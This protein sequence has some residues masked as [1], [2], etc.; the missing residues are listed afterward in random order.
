MTV[1]NCEITIRPN[2]A[3]QILSKQEANQLCDHSDK[4]LNDLLRR[5]ALAVLNTG[6]NLDSGEKLLEMHPE[7]DIKVQSR[8]R[9][10]E[11]ILCNPPETAFIDGEMIEGLREHLFAVVRDLIYVRNSII[12]SGLFDL[13]TSK[14]I[15]NAVFHILRNAEVLRTNEEPNLVACW[16]GHAVSRREYEYSRHVGISLGERRLNIC[17]GCG[18]GVMKGPMRGAEAGHH[19]QRFNNRRYIGLSEPGIIA[20]E[21]PNTVVNELV[22]LPDIEKRLEAFVRLAHGIVIFPGGPGTLEELLYI[23]SIML[24]PKNANL[25]YPLVLT[26]D[27]G[28]H[29]YFDE[30]KH[31]I[32]ATLGEI[33]AERLNIILGDATSVA[34]YMRQSM[35][36]VKEDRK[37]TSDAYYF[38]WQ[39]HIEPELQMP[40]EPTHASMRALNLT[41]NQPAHQLAAQLRCAFSGIVAGNVKAEGLRA[42]A[43][44]GPFELKGDPQ[45]MQALGRLLD[46]M[47]QQKRMKIDADNYIPSYRII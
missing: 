27:H 37:Q 35:Q 1:K 47:I 44:H 17:T 28:S 42:I 5:C 31:F 14:G 20:A 23:L 41:K 22:I 30:V 15:T 16:G 11:L 25:P 39:L 34:S 4:G 2:G 26:G 33:A 19:N 6:N 13:T 7:F 46:F 38:N 8:G 12:D 43:Q 9:G 24:D 40:F 21:A 45:I 3:L 29:A 36:L 18:P 32:A 10:I